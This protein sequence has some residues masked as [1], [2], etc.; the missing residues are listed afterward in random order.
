MTHGT[1]GW[2]SVATVNLPGA[3]SIMLTSAELNSVF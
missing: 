2:T 1:V 3:V